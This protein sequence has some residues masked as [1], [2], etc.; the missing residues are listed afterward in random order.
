MQQVF[1]GQADDV[2]FFAM[3]EAI[4]RN[5]VAMMT[6]LSW[7]AGRSGGSWPMLAY[8]QVV[9]AASTCRGNQVGRPRDISFTFVRL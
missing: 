7:S 1:T 9:N 2:D 5:F 3:V 6:R 4:Y 8:Q